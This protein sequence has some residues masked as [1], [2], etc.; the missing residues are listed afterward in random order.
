MKTEPKKRIDPV[1]ILKKINRRPSVKIGAGNEALPQLSEEDENYKTNHIKE[2]LEDPDEVNTT[3]SLMRAFRASDL[4][5]LDMALDASEAIQARN[6]IEK[7]LAHQMAA[8][9]DQAMRLL[10]KA[11]GIT[12]DMVDIQRLVNSSVRLMNTFQQALQTLHKLRTGGRQVVT[13]RHQHVNVKDGGQAVVAGTIKGGG[14][15]SSKQRGEDA[16]KSDS[17]P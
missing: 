7:M 3:A 1:D 11:N 13:V 15:E 5:I 16:K 10:F 8:C 2:T 4:M 12:E 6:S 14:G 9:H 17:T